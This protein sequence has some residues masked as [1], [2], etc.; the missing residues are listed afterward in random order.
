M[1]FQGDK[2]LGVYSNN[3]AI[4]SPTLGKHNFGLDD[5]E[6]PFFLPLP[7][8]SASK[9]SVSLK[10]DEQDFDSDIFYFCHIHE[11]MTGRIKLLKNG[12]PVTRKNTPSLKYEY[13]SPGSFDKQCGTFGL[14]DYQLPNKQC[15]DRFVCDVPETDPNL[16]LYA[17]CIEAMNC[18]M[19]TGMT[20]MAT[21]NSG[22]AL[23]IHHMIPH[24]QNAVNMAKATLKFANLECDDLTKE[25]ND[26]LYETILREIING[27]NFEIQVCGHFCLLLSS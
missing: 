8:W 3:E 9:F 24:H 2:Y 18:H 1:Y 13:D 26:C 21:S 10:F 23:F 19:L 7:E 11:L 5:Y 16:K 17:Q 14:D 25:T 20:S 22:V 6:P 27:Q 15:F 12:V 4:D